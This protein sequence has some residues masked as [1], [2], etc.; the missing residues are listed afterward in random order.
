M[1]G[2]DPTETPLQ[3]DL[4]GGRLEFLREEILSRHEK[5]LRARD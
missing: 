3:R 2:A 5:D 1:V 4:L